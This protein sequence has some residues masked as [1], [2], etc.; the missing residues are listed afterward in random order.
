MKFNLEDRPP[1]ESRFIV[2]N[3]RTKLWEDI[4]DRRS[5]ASSMRT[6]LDARSSDPDIRALFG[7]M[8]LAGL[9]MAFLVVS[10]VEER[11]LGA[12]LHFQAGPEGLAS[13]VQS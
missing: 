12:N 1:L 13:T 10:E 9:V 4:I 5:F 2:R 8:F 11:T 3:Q 6:S 7:E